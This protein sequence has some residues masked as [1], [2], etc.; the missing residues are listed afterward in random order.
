MTILG[1]NIRIIGIDGKFDDCQ[2]LVKKAFM[3][4]GL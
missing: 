1:R 2:H 3:D 4:P